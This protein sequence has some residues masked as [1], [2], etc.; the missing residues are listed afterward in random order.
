VQMGEVAVPITAIAAIEG[1]A[2]L[3]RVPRIFLRNGSVLAGEMEFKNFAFKV[4]DQWAVEKWDPQELNL[5]LLALNPTDGTPPANTAAFVELRS[6]EVYPV[7]AMSPGLTLVSVWGQRLLPLSDLADLQ[8]LSNPRP[9][10]RAN[11]TD[12]S[13][14]S[15]FPAREDLQITLAT[16]PKNITIKPNQIRRIWKSEIQPLMPELFKPRWTELADIPKGLIPKG[17]FLLQGNN[18]LAG[19]FSETSSITVIDGNSAFD[20]AP[21]QIAAMRKLDPSQRTSLPQFEIE[22]ANGDVIRGGI[23]QSTLLIGSEK[24]SWPIPV[25]QIIFYQSAL[26][27]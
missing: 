13:S 9:E 20:V 11:L 23:R 14:I 7:A 17:G 2:G 8:Y 6:G 16:E 22:L 21:A 3:G 10:C 27:R 12:G 18:L 4:G 19:G 5:L 15:I 25:R 26:P 24:K 1:G